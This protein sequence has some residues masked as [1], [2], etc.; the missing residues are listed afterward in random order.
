MSE[1][2]QNFQVKIGSEKN[3]GITFSVVFFVLSFY[4]LLHKSSIMYE[5]ILISLVFLSISLIK[6]V[7]LKWPNIIWFKLGMFLGGIIAPIIMAI[8]YIFTVIPVGLILK[9]FQKDILLLKIDKNKNSYWIDKTVS[10]K[11]SMNRQY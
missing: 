7:L 3:F 1:I 4:P 11:S 5:L 9:I 2:N 8:V 6:P 10:N